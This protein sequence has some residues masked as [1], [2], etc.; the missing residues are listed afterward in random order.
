MDNGVKV[1][2]ESIEGRLNP[3]GIDCCNPVFHFTI[4]ATKQNVKTPVY[5]V[6]VYDE[7]GECQW[8]TSSHKWNGAPYI[9]YQGKPLKPKTE[10]EVKIRVWDEENHP[11]PYSDSVKFETGFLGTSW[12]ASWIEPIQEEAIP[13]PELMFFQ[14]FDSKPE[15][16]EGATRLKPSHHVRRKFSVNITKD[17]SIRKV[18]IYASAHGVY[19]VYLN[20]KKVDDRRLAPETSVYEKILYYQTYDVT[21]QILQGENVLGITVA[22]GWWIGRLGISG[23]SCQYGNKLGLILQM[24]ISYD[25]GSTEVIGSDE[26]FCSDVAQIL[27]SDLYIGEKWN[28]DNEKTMWNTI[29]FDDSQWKPC[30][31]VV[32]NKENLIGQFTDS[33]TVLQELEVEQILI[34]PK[35]ELVLDFGQVIAGV[36]RFEIEGV[37][38]H[39]LIFQHGEVLDEYGNYKNN[40]IGRNKNQQDE[41][42]CRDGN[43][44]FEPLFTYH[45]FRYVKVSGI[46]ADQLKAKALVIGTPLKKTGY[47]ECSHTTLNQLQHNIEWSILGNMCSIPT[48]CPQREKLGWTGDIQVFAKTGMYNYGMKNFLESWLKNLHADQ[49]MNGEVPVTVPNHPLQDRLQRQM[50]K[51]QNSSSGW[52]DAAVLLPLYLYQHYG[53]VTILRDCLESMEKWMDYVKAQAASYP[54]GYEQMSTEAKRRNPFLWNKGFHFG[55]WLIPSLRSLPNGVMLGSELTGALVGS[56]FYAVSVAAMIEVYEALR[57]DEKTD[58]YEALKYDEKNDVYEALRYDEKIDAYKKLLVEIRAAIRE[59]YVADDG[60]VGKETT[61]LQ[62]LYVMVLKAKAVDG[63][64]KEKVVNRLVSLIRENDTCL[65]TGFSSVSYLLDVLYENGRKD[66]AYELLFQRKSPSWLYMVDKGATTIWENWNAITSGGE[67]TDSSYNH[68]A[69]GSIGEW[70]YTHIGGIVSMAPGY[71]S[72]RI[73]PDFSCGITKAHSQCNTPFGWIRVAWEYIDNKISMDVTIPVNVYCEIWVE[74]EVK[75]LGSGV[76]QL[77]F[78]LPDEEICHEKNPC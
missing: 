49:M 20:G 24:E 34:T 58:V 4:E 38:G 57:Y 68:Y 78:D 9:T 60:T 26:L 51:G 31:K 11:S 23:D 37:K 17:R 65:D 18:R 1:K 63:V 21:E 76:H 45:G 50:S 13:E 15:F 12:S 73:Q 72:I 56:C 39:H 69:F 62:G 3:L 40:I 36:C 35:G 28:L 64:L 46:G 70:I 52:G 27:Y 44:I 25:D 74:Q 14:L 5:Q 2:I 16:L 29:L 55:D 8:D 59:E 48:D 75:I 54:E 32:Y 10:Y 43:Q 7:S 77:R 41:L 42:I 53:D 66:I 61:E 71:K 47:F 19:Q 22:D 6:V 67:V 33:I 30:S